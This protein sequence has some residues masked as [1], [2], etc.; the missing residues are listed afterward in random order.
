MGR[1]R[2]EGALGL[3]ELTSTFILSHNDGSGEQEA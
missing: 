1:E 3:G 2:R